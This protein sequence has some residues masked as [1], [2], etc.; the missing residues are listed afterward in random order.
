MDILRE[1]KNKGTFQGKLKNPT[2]HEQGQP[3]NWS[4]PVACEH[5][6]SL[7]EENR[8]L[9]IK[10]MDLRDKLKT[11]KM[12]PG[13]VQKLESLLQSELPV[14]AGPTTAKSTP[15]APSLSSSTD[16]GPDPEP[17]IT[18]ALIDRCTSH[19][20]QK[21]V[22]ELLHGLYTREYWQAIQ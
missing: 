18:K 2:S 13:I 20:P 11:L 9:L 19:N 7:Q 21:F 17:V 4:P 1:L 6:L 22:N 14:L 3:T 5:C 16:N 10:N 15:E 8:K 12:L